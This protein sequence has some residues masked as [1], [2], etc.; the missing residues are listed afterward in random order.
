MV[1]QEKA[2]LLWVGEMAW[3]VDK[4]TGALS[5]LESLDR[6]FFEREDSD[7]TATSAGVVSH[8]NYGPRDFGDGYIYEVSDGWLTRVS[9]NGGAMEPLFEKPSTETFEAFV[10]F[11]SE[12][13]GTNEDGELWH[14]R[15]LPEPT[16]AV[17]LE[18]RGTWDDDDYSALI[19]MDR[20]AV[21]WEA[22]ADIKLRTI[23]G[24][25]PLALY[26]TCRPIK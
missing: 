14:A 13:Y 9:N 26:R 15:V 23:N 8:R 16:A 25:D 1:M 5:I 20:D 24:D 22:G 7:Y 17:L 4:A 2:V 3:S 6:G 18:Q 21:Y 10:V 19:G 11:D 12:F